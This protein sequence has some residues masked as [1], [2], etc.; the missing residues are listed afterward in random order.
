MEEQNTMSS[1]ETNKSKI[2]PVKLAIFPIGMGND[3]Y[4]FDLNSNGILDVKTG[5]RNSEYISDTN[6]IEATENK[7]KK[8][9]EVEIESVTKVVTEIDNDKTVLEKA[10]KK[11]G[12]E[13]IIL[14]DNEKYNFNYGDYDDI[15]YGKLVKLLIQYSPLK[16]DIHSWS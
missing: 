8:L 14:I 7:N 15:S 6:F 9:S 2:K 16:V 1:T 3:T 4:L 11:G 10:L 12:W 13:V 5:N